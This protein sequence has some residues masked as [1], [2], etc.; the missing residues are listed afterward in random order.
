M[1]GRIR[2]SA[3]DDVTIAR[4]LHVLAVVLWIGGVAFVT[5]VLL[6]TVRNIRAAADRVVFFENVERRFSGQARFMTTLARLTGFYMLVRLDLWDRFLTVEYWWMHAMVA[7]WLLFTLMLFVAEPL[8]LDRWLL[9]RA[10]ARPEATFRLI[11]RLHWILLALSL[12]TL[13]GAVLG[14]HGVLIIE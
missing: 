4:A 9:A 13:I 12:I 2:F 14:S 10:K 6:P 5:T 1:V 3:V 11:E 8:F 7:V